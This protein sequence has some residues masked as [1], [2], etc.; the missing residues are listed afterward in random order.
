MDYE[1]IGV[2][3]RGQVSFVM[4]LTPFMTAGSWSLLK[5]SSDAGIYVTGPSLMF[6]ITCTF[7][8]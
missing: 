6:T 5:T 4:D 2:I 8:E 1:Y 3:K 7:M